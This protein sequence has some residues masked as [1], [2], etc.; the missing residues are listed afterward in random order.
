MALVLNSSVDSV[1]FNTIGS[2]SVYV[3]PHE[4]YT[5]TDTQ[6]MDSMLKR[7]VGASVIQTCSKDGYVLSGTASTRGASRANRALCKP[8]EIVSRSTGTVPHEHLNGAL[9]YQVCYRHLVC[10]PPLDVVIPAVV[11]D[12]NKLGMRCHYYPYTFDEATRTVDA[13]DVV[14]GGA[15]FLAVFLPKALHFN[16]ALESGGTD[17][18]VQTL[19]ERY[20]RE[21]A[22]VDTPD[23]DKQLIVYVRIRQKRF[24]LN[25]K[26]IATIGVLHSGPVEIIS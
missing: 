8:L 24:D 18:E 26:A 17:E 2:T 14:K 11:C 20:E 7:K 23:E 9:V 1:C 10:N 16:L 19:Q 25:D 15:N 6:S 4:L 3:R 12:A 22:R 5:L 13:G 21:S